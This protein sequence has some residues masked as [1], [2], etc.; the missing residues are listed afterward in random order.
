MSKGFP[1]GRRGASKA[2]GIVNDPNDWKLENPRYIME[3][4][5]RCATVAVQTNKIVNTVP[6]YTEIQLPDDWPVEWLQPVKK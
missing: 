2:S 6:R 5:G 1:N 3:L 4:V